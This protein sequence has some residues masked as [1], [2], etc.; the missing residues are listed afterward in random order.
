MKAAAYLRVSTSDQA[1]DGTSLD[2][3]RRR[4]IG[5]VE[6]RAWN[7]LDVYEDGGV[8]GRNSQELWNGT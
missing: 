1:Q 5:Y 3:Q 2:D 8:S 4:C 7:L 6:S